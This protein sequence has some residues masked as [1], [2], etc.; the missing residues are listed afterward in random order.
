MKLAGS[1]SYF[2]KGD[3]A[4]LEQ[5]VLRFTY[6]LLIERGFMPMSSRCWS[7]SRR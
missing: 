4:R 3:G 6:D 5:A 1:R 2:L 7:P